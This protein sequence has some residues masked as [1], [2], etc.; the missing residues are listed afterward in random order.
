MY[1]PPFIL[2]CFADTK[3]G[4]RNTLPFLAVVPTKI[5]QQGVM[6]MLHDMPTNVSSVDSPKKGVHV[7][8]WDQYG[9]HTAIEGPFHASSEAGAPSSH[10]GSEGSTKSDDAS[11]PIQLWDV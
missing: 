11:I 10:P 3:F 1:L 2:H 8:W 6:A 4:H 7:M 5:V 9:M